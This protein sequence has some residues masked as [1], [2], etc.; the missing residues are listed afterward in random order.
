MT[1]SDNINIKLEVCRDKTSGKLTILAHF[2]EDAPNIIKDKGEYFWM[3]TTEEKDLLNEAFELI[4]IDTPHIT[5]ENTPPEPV[6]EIDV[7][8]EPELEPKSL[9][10]KLEEI[11]PMEKA[12]P[13]SVFDK[14]NDE[15]K[16]NQTEKDIHL[17]VEN[18]TPEMEEPMEQGEM[19]IQNEPESNELEHEK[20][21]ED[22]GLIV[23]AD[24]E[25]IDEA[26][27]KHTQKDKSIVEA[28]EQT[29]VDKVLSQKKKGKWSKS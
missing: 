10:D 9:E 24:S 29:I 2:N 15:N 20:S 26:L 28:D 18:N 25:A 23:E 27:K 3:P 19:E 4:P 1:K 8:T 13:P 5:T 17:S 6:P 16:E 11:P 22:N 14:F 21:K 12:D 7:K